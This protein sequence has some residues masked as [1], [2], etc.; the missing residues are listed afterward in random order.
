MGYFP[1]SLTLMALSAILAGIVGVALPTGQRLDSILALIAGAGAGVLVIAIGL[2]RGSNATSASSMERLF[3]IGS[4]VGAAAV[5][6]VLIVLW[7]HARP[8]RG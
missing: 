6:L 7:R 5:A 8:Y 3:F 4:C 2:I 1:W